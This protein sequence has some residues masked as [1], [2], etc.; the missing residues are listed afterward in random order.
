MYILN[1]EGKT[2]ENCWKKYPKTKKNRVSHNNT[3]FFLLPLFPIWEIVIFLLHTTRLHN[4]NLFLHVYVCPYFPFS[5][6]FFIFRIIEINWIEINL[7]LQNSLVKKGG[8]AD[9]MDKQDVNNSNIVNN[10]RHFCKNRWN[11][12]EYFLAHFCLA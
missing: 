5:I 6:L 1:H 11:R 10:F 3:S 12:S 9:I 4:K 8:K 2:K 7:N